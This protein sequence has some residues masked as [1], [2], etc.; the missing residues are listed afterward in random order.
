MH[1][2]NNFY[3]SKY[4]RSIEELFRIIRVGDLEDV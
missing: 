2:W 3:N 1:R 4:E